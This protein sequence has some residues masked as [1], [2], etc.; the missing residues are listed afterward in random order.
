MELCMQRVS[1]LHGRLALPGTE[2]RVLL[3]DNGDAAGGS[4]PLERF[5]QYRRRCSPARL[6]RARRPRKRQRQ[7]ACAPLV[8]GAARLVCRTAPGLSAIDGQAGLTNK[9]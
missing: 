2:L 6:V 5:W 9:S 8:L 4:A 7:S 1:L 3:A